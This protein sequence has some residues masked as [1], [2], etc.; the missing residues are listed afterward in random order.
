MPSLQSQKVKLEMSLKSFEANLEFMDHELDEEREKVVLA[1]ASA[2]AT[3]AQKHT[4]PALGK[5]DIP[6]EYYETMELDRT[7]NRGEK[8][9]GR[10]VIYNLR[11]CVRNPESRRFAKQFGKLLRD[12]FE[13]VVV[14]K[15]RKHRGTYFKPC[16][17][18]DEARRNAVEDYRGLMRASWGMSFE[19][20]GRKA[21]PAFR[22]YTTRRPE[23]L[24]RKGLSHAMFEKNIM[25]VTLR[26]DVIPDNAG[27]LTST[28]VNAS[29]AAVRTMDDMMTKFFKKKFD[30]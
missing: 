29:I 25:T 21:P 18:L 27:F 7:M 13:Y 5:P 11:N 23:L 14:M 10:R 4:P 30:L 9:G 3:S 16:R 22:K 28:D 15:N 8:T 1:G 20:V 2:Y 19:N 26:N 6:P 17:T 12:G 24:K